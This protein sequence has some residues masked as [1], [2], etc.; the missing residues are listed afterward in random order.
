MVSLSYLTA[1]VVSL[2]GLAALD[3]R[4]KLAFFADFWRAMLVQAVALAVFV[5]WDLAGIGSGIFL[6]GQSRYATGIFLL[7]QFPLEELFF[8]MLLTY[9]P[10]IAWQGLAVWR[11][12]T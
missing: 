7:P 3:W 1:L 4:Y 6:A 2:A 5:C 11:K 9:L 8:L 12:T 10:L